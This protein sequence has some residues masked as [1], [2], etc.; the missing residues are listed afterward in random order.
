M[1]S[2][3]GLKMEQV[4]ERMIEEVSKNVHLYDSS[5]LQCK[6]C[7]MAANSWG[8]AFDYGDRNTSGKT[9]GESQR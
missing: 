3:Y 8:L 4:E 9:L 7:Q 1:V 2:T 5:S 6:G